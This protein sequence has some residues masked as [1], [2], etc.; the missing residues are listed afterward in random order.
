VSTDVVDGYIVICSISTKALVTACSNDICFSAAL[1][2]HVRCCPCVAR[3]KCI[4]ATV[5]RHVIEFDKAV[6][7]WARGVLEY[8]LPKV[9]LTELKLFVSVICAISS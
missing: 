4:F 5:F 9:L 1:P 2:F 8:S 3:V 6:F 7:V